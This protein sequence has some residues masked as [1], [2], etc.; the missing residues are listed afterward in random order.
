MPLHASHTATTHHPYYTNGEMK[1]SS[2]SAASS[3]SLSFA[4]PSLSLSSSSSLSTNHRRQ[5]QPSHHSSATPLT[6]S[7]S[8]SLYANGG[9][10][11]GRRIATQ[12]HTA[13]AHGLAQGHLPVSLHEVMGSYFAFNLIQYH[14]SS[15]DALSL[16]PPPVSQV[17]LSLPAFNPLSPHEP[18]DY[19]FEDPPVHEVTL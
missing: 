2:A 17:K 10:N 7:S 19:D 18:D 13:L 4:T 6:S 3:S 5:P 14:I 15:T 1:T 16:S 12:G 9:R 8:S 11:G